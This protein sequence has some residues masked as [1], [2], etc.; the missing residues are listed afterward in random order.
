MVL[1]IL[2]IVVVILEY[3]FRSRCPSCGSWFSANHLRGKILHSYTDYRTVRRNDRDVQEAY[4]KHQIE[5]S[6][7]CKKCGFE[8]EKITTDTS[9][10]N[11]FFRS[12]TL[13]IAGI[14]VILYFLVNVVGSHTTSNTQDH[15]T[16]DSMIDN[17]SNKEVNADINDK[18]LISIAN[19]TH[20]R[21]TH[22]IMKPKEILSEEK[23]EKISDENISDTSKPIHNNGGEPSVLTPTEYNDA[24]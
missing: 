11:P 10:R 23:P 16:T 18:S 8:W 9:I 14:L 17:S 4:T 7:R 21:S 3:G 2:L 24:N 5:H 20:E 12:W 1:I 6:F 19:K 15:I 13:A 22:E